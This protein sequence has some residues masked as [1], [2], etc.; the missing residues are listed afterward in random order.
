LAY[1]HVCSIQ[2]QYLR[3]AIMENRGDARNQGGQGQGSTAKPGKK[4]GNVTDRERRDQESSKQSGRPSP[5]GVPNE[6]KGTPG[7][8]GSND[9]RGRN[10]QS[11]YEYKGGR[12]S[13]GGI[14]N[15]DDQDDDKSASSFRGTAKE[16]RDSRNRQL[17]EHPN[18]RE[19]QTSDDKTRN[20]A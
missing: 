9:D 2:N 17:N 5:S 6:G 7:Q 20:P 1:L 16:N 19:G 15:P 3:G 10:V 14:P 13:T 11:G 12:Q 18:Q 8:P 4:P